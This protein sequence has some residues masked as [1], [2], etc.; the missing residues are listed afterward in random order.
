MLGE[1]AQVETLGV[2]QSGVDD[3]GLARASDV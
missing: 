3:A 1:N 2:L